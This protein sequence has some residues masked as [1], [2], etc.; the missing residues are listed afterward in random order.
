MIPIKS[1]SLPKKK[2]NAIYA[3]VEVHLK[4]SEKSKCDR[5][6]EKVLKEI[7]F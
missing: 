7:Y 1:T 3:A 4:S 5:I 2:I 6:P